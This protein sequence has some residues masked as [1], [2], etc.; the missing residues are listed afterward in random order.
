MLEMV[1]KVAPPDA[2]LEDLSRW[3]YSIIMMGYSLAGSPDYPAL[4]LNASPSSESYRK[5]VFEILHFIF[6][7]SLM[8]ITGQPAKKASGT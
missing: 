2:A 5:R 7:P 8:G 1:L 3:L 6:L 4:F